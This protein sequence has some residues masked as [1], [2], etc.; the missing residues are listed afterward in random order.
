MPQRSLHRLTLLTGVFVV[1]LAVGLAGT[2]YLAQAGATGNTLTGGSHAAGTGPWSGMMPSGGMMG[3]TSWSALN[4]VT[5]VATQ[6]ITM[7]NHDA[8]APQV[9]RVT[10]GTTVTWT[11]TDTDAHTVTFM[12]GMLHSVAVASQGQFQI[13]FTAA[14][15]YDYLCLYHQGMV[16]RVIVAA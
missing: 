14:G 4:A 6:T 13:T 11:N 16:G 15:T 1:L 7:T 3:G 9:I 10:P 12:P 2:A 5:P 8:F